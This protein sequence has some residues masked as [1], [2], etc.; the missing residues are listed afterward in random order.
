MYHPYMATCVC[1]ACG[2]EHRKRLTAAERAENGRRAVGRRWTRGCELA[3]GPIKTVEEAE[4]AAVRVAGE[5]AKGG[6]YECLT[7]RVFMVG[8]IFCELAKEQGAAE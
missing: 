6:V 5:K 8:C 3:G 2:R 1:A 4:R 7:H